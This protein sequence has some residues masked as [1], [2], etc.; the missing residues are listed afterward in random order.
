MFKNSHLRLLMKLVGMELLTPTLDETP[1]SS[2]ILPG[3]LT[4]EALQESLDL[5]NKAEFSPPTF[6][7]G[8][9]AEDQLRRRSAVRKRAAYD[10]D[11]D[12]DGLLDD[13]EDGILFPAGGPTARKFTAEDAPRAKK[14]LRRRR[15]VS[16]EPDP[17]TD[18]QLDERARARR[19]R[20]LEKARKIK[21]SV[22]V[23]PADDETDDEARELARQN[24]NNRPAAGSVWD[25]ILGLGK[26]DDT[27]SQAHESKA[28]AKTT[29][30]KRS[31]GIMSDSSDEEEVEEIPK[32]RPLPKRRRQ[33]KKKPVVESDEEMASDQSS[34]TADERTKSDVETGTND[35]PLS[36]SPGHLGGGD[37]GEEEDDEDVV[38]SRARVRIRAGFVVDSSD[39]E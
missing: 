6:Q 13:D 32:K 18:E 30:R 26:E 19:Q 17:L 1:D 5:I 38:A 20:E 10:D 11:D 24:T 15:A 33:T 8:T 29:Q 14:R 28:P 3:T 4:S 39:E 37:K 23:D 22:Y 36:S 27:S 35:T 7:D 9:L 16:Q 2:W 21:S 34:A 12:L 31:S 25:S